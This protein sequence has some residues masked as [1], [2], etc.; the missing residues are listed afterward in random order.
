MIKNLQTSLL[1]RE[2]ITQALTFAIKCMDISES[3]DETDLKMLKENMGKLIKRIN[4]E[5]SPGGIYIDGER[6]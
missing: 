2:L 3:I 1:D 6:Q 4:G 5:E